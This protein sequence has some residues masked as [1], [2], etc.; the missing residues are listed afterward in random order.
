MISLDAAAQQLRAVWR[1]AFTRDWE[2]TSRDWRETLDRS[3]DGVFQSFW[4]ILFAAPIAFVGFIG[5]RRAAAQLQPQEISPLLELP[6]V[7]MM[8]IEYTAYLADWAASIAVIVLIARMT[9]TTATIS[10]TVI[11]YNWA[12]VYAIGFQVFP[13]LLMMLTG[14]RELTSI[15]ALPILIM[16]LVLYWG[17]FRRAMGATPGITIAIIIILTLV[18]VIVRAIVSSIVLYFF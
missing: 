13:I 12:Q 3:L 8:I 10:D 7:V 5:V 6:M 17:L 14:S 9:K 4:A 1:M 15:S 2:D 16:V 11:C 18:S